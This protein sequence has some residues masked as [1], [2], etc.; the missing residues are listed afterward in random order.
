MTGRSIHSFMLTALVA[1]A[2]IRRHCTC[3][4]GGAFTGHRRARAHE[5]YFSRQVSPDADAN[6][7]PTTRNNPRPLPARPSTHLRKRV[8]PQEN[9]LL[10]FLHFVLV[11]LS[12]RALAQTLAS[13]ARIM[14]PLRNATATNSFSSENIATCAVFASTKRK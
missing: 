3:L 1:P 14:R 7:T 13:S 12:L 9:F 6:R 4:V 10:F 11:V 2:G 8:S 5:E